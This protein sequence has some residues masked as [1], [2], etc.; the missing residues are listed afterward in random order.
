MLL[1]VIMM[2]CFQFCVSALA[3]RFYFVRGR[4]TVSDTAFL[5][6]LSIPIVFGNIVSGL[7]PGAFLVT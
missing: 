5:L 6:I 4:L 2:S 1:Y 7:T 3:E